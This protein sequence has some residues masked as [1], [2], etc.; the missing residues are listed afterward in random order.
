M[1][2]ECISKRE[3]HQRVGSIV[4]R[5][6]PAGFNPN[7]L[8][9][10]QKFCAIYWE[11]HNAPCPTND[12]ASFTCLV[13]AACIEAA[14]LF[15]WLPDHGCMARIR[16]DFSAAYSGRAQGFQYAIDKQNLLRLFTILLALPEAGICNVFLDKFVNMYGAILSKIGFTETAKI[17]A[18]ISRY[19]PSI[20]FDKTRLKLSKETLNGEID[21][22]IASGARS[23]PSLIA[24]LPFIRVDILEKFWKNLE[25][26]L[27]DAQTRESHQLEMPSLSKSSPKNPQQKHELASDL[28]PCR[29]SLAEDVTCASGVMPPEMRTVREPDDDLLTERFNALVLKSF[30]YGIRPRLA[31]D[32]AKATAAWLE[33]FGVPFVEGEDALT[34][35]ARKSC[36]EVDGTFYGISL[37]AIAILDAEIATIHNGGMNTVY[38]DRLYQAHSHSLFAAGLL[39]ADIMAGAIKN[40]YPYFVFAND[41]FR[42][43]KAK[44]LEDE[45]LSLAEGRDN[46]VFYELA[47]ALPFIPQDKL[48]DCLQNCI[49]LEAVNDDNFVRV[50]STLFDEDER[51]K[52]LQI[53]KNQLTNDGYCPSQ[54][55]SLNRSADNN[56]D[57]PKEILTKIFVRLVLGDQYVL[58]GG[59]IRKI[60][61][62]LKTSTLI[63]NYCL[64]HSSFRLDE[65]AAYADSLGKRGNVHYLQIAQNTS[66]QIDANRFVALDMIDFDIDAIDTALDIVIEK[67]MSPLLSVSSF[68]L[69]PAISGYRWNHHLLMSY[70][71]LESNKYT[72][73]CPAHNNKCV[74]IICRKDNKENNYYFLAANIAIS[75]NIE[76]NINSVENYALSKGL[77]GRKRTSAVR[78]L[79]DAMQTLSATG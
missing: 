9:D 74:G 38:F 46:I 76:I 43:D 62:N 77:L 1:A 41:H 20:V 70:C 32:R 16:R 56:P 51:E 5:Y 78:Q 61:T 67:R 28:V 3:L 65:L 79:Y 8:A 45:I 47:K 52:C 58:R 75:D 10:R 63:R 27:P 40:R 12:V 71:L 29:S 53:V 72:F 4:F 49:R 39:S 30:K 33:M 25:R 2:V 59:I 69:F 55:L 6:F 23:L 18:I 26:A 7:A 14:N 60:D 50:D 73:L 24:R 13:K 54:L 21:R 42:I 44:T 15:F 34:S 31:A 48:K 19:L 11:R 35:L 66:I 37:E 68:H 57:V 36:A 64:E 17:K 22:A